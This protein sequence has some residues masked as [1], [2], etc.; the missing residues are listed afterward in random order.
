[1]AS[2]TA[3]TVQRLSTDVVVLGDGCA[4]LFLTTKLFQ[5]GYKVVLINPRSE[6]GVNDIRPKDGLSLWNA[7]FK[8]Q[9]LT[10][11]LSNL[12]DDFGE[13]VKEAFPVSITEAGLKKTESCGVLSSVPIHKEVTTQL[14]EEY[15]KLERKAWSA[16]HVRLVNPDL[17]EMKLKPHGLKVFSVASI[18]G[19][20]VRDYGVTWDFLNIGKN[21]SEFVAQKIKEEQCISFKGAQIESKVG[22]RLTI[23]HEGKKIQVEYNTGCY[24]MLTGDLIPHIK[25]VVKSASQ[26]APWLLGLRKRRREQHHA[27][28]K[29]NLQKTHGLPE[30]FWLHLGN[31]HYLWGAKQSVASWVSRSGP[32]SLDT[33]IDEGI[34]LGLG[35]FTSYSRN[36]RLE[37]DW[38]TPQWK[39]TPYQ[40]FWASAFEGDLLPLMELLWNSPT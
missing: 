14:E 34:R 13:K 25:D 35:S 22:R 12:W 9:G 15:F 16:G 6:F 5:Q 24:V 19:A 11:N 29:R 10:I 8:S 40:T 23:V 38:K 31:V 27:L 2:A 36:F 32:D 18:D 33:V 30:S 17:L 28:F 4:A 21:L 20:L 7:A 39:E 3:K 37:W 1:M 26:R